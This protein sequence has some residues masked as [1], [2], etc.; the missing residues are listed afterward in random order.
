MSFIS[1]TIRDR[2]ISG[3]FWTAMVPKTTP[4][5]HLKNFDFSE[6]RPPSCISS[7]RQ[8]NSSSAHWCCIKIQIQT[9]E[10]EIFESRVN[11]FNKILSIII[12]YTY[13]Q[14]CVVKTSFIHCESLSN[15][16]V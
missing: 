5:L 6:F 10:Q 7:K 12:M 4:L 8:G 16:K 3:K 14:K 1:K 13:R 2:A 15:E 9:S 11:I